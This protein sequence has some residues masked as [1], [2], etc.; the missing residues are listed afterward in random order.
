VIRGSFRLAPDGSPLQSTPASETHF[1]VIARSRI[2]L[3]RHELDLGQEALAESCGV[4]LQQVQKYESGINRVSFSR[5]VQ[6]A[7]TLRCRVGDIVLEADAEVSE[8]LAGAAPQRRLR[9]KG[10]DELLALFMQLSPIERSTLID[11]FRSTAPA[12]TTA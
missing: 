8:H 12:A 6:I 2:R 4:T 11:L 5:L 7:V 1:P 10:A 3:R 9:I